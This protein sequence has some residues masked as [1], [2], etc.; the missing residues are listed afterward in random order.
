[1]SAVTTPPTTG[2]EPDAPIEDSFLRRYV[3]SHTAWFEAIA[4]AAGGRTVRHAT[5]SGADVGRA[6]GFFNS[7]TL[8]QPLSATNVEV[9]LDEIGEWFGRRAVFLWSAW[10]TPDLSSR[11]WQLVGHPPLLLRPPTGRLPDA[12]PSL[13]A[14]RVVDASGLRDWEHVIAYGFPLEHLQGRS[15]TL[16][17][18]RLFED[19]RVGIWVGYEDDRPVTTGSLFTHVGVAQ[20]ALAATLPQARR[21]G[22]WFTLVRVRL[23]AAGDT[24]TA[25]LF[26]DLSRPGAESLG[27]MPILRFTCWHRPTSEPEPQVIR[28]ANA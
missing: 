10:P 22:Y 6:A 24:P 1:M 9:T 27:F 17:G 25:A 20:F 16:V 26:S 12:H 4:G 3:F 19:P 28:P 23:Q 15:A 13:R 21:R 18:E 14:E 7:A 2:W 5:W 8:L 11:G